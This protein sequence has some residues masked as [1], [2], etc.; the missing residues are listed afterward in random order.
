MDPLA[1]DLNNVLALPS[2]HHPLGTDDLGRDI[3]SRLIF[4]IREWLEVGF[5]S[6]LLAPVCGASLGLWA[7]PSAET[8]A[9]SA[10]LP[11]MVPRVFG[12]MACFSDETTASGVM[13]VPSRNFTP[14]RIGIRISV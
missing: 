12:S 13:A 2:L 1:Q 7:A 11:A 9:I 6:A 10:R 3:L 14:P 5:N 4:G 8:S